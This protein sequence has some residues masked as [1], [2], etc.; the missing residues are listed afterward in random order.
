VL[1]GGASLLGYS[2]IYVG[3]HYP[4]DVLTGAALGMIASELIRRATENLAR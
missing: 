4:G 2:R 3:A 1:F